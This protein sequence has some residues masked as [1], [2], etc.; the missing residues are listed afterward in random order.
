MR[1]LGPS[2]ASAR[3]AH[4]GASK[5]AQSQRAV[6]AEATNAKAKAATDV[7]TSSDT[8]TSSAQRG[9]LAAT[10]I[11]ASLIMVRKEER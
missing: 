3:P 9:A 7:A 10:A 5:S 4:P 1:I 8:A 2:R 6:A 11:A